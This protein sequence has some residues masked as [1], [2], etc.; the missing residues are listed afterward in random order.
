MTS[1]RQAYRKI[2]LAAANRMDKRKSDRNQNGG[3]SSGNTEAEHS[4]GS[5]KGKSK[6]EQLERS[7][8]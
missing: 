1:C 5:F 4:K 3:G 2:D 6:A 7:H 8:L